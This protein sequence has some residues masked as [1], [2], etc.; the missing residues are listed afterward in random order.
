M[1]RQT[2]S[3][4]GVRQLILQ[5][6]WLLSSALMKKNFR[7]TMSFLNTTKLHQFYLLIRAA[8]RNLRSDLRQWLPIKCT[9]LVSFWRCA[10]FW[11]IC[12]DGCHRVLVAND[13]LGR[14]WKSSRLSRLRDKVQLHSKYAAFHLC[15]CTIFDKTIAPP[16]PCYWGCMVSLYVAV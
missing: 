4:D 1:D 7:L 13:S 8:G 2:W 3:L 10:C 9:L 12:C 6:L 5:V 16:S 11:A 14:G 15:A